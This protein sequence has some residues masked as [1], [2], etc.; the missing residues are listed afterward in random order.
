MLV[1]C[2]NMTI[3]DDCVQFTSS[4][5]LHVKYRDGVVPQSPLQIFDALCANKDVRENFSYAMLGREDA[6]LEKRGKL[7]SGVLSLGFKLDDIYVVNVK[8]SSIHKVQ[9]VGAKTDQQALDV[10]IDTF[11]VLGILSTVSHVAVEP[12]TKFF[13]VKECQNDFGVIMKRVDEY[14]P[15][16]TIYIPCTHQHKLKLKVPCNTFVQQ[17][18]ASFGDD[19]SIEKKSTRVKSSFAVTFTKQQS[20]GMSCFGKSAAAIREI[21]EK[22]FGK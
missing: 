14:Y 15:E 8:H 3:S 22:V 2:A 10:F 6:Q 9:V 18:E 1:L 4:Y 20:G 13:R 7:K 16:A 17:L 5:K 12:T 19:G 21:R 11:R